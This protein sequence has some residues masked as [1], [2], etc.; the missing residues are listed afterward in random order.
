MSVD[1]ALA[2]NEATKLASLEPGTPEWCERV[3]CISEPDKLAKGRWREE[4]HLVSTI[5]TSEPPARVTCDKYYRLRLPLE[6]GEATAMRL[7]EQLGLQLSYHR[8]MGMQYECRF[9]KMS[10]E[11]DEVVTRDGH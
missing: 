1:P 5:K 11:P 2:E 8:D 9:W 7:V 3:Y 4:W 10:G 6:G